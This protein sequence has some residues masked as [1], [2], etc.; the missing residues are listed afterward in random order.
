MLTDVRSWL[1]KR[2]QASFTV[3]EIDPLIRGRIDI[4]QYYAG[5]SRA[6]MFV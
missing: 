5:A 4:Q 3:G 1:I 2:Y 6:R